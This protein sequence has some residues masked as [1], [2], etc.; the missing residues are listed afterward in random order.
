MS[1]EN[2]AQDSLC[3]AKLFSSPIGA[4]APALLKRAIGQT[5]NKY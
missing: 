4:F 1:N 2:E 5:S 3:A